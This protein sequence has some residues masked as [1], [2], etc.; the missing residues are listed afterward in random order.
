MKEWGHKILANFANG[1]A[2]FWG[3]RVFS[4]SCGRPHVQLVNLFLSAI[5]KNFLDLF[6]FFGVTSLT[7]FKFTVWLL[8]QM[9]YKGLS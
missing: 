7:L 2:W 5:C 8:K 3:K 1:S 4:N 6:C 9:K